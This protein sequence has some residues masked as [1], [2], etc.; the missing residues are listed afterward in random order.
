MTGHA[1]ADAD[2]VAAVAAA[3]GLSAGCGAS[4]SGRLAVGFSC[5]ILRGL[6]EKISAV[7]LMT[8]LISALSQMLFSD[9]S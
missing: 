9:A 8:S 2:A 4:A 1:L 7:L 6:S 3:C 5:A